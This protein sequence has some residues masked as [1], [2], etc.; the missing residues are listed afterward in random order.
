LSSFEFVV[1]YTGGGMAQGGR[2]PMTRY[3]AEELAAYD[4]V[5]NIEYRLKPGQKMK[6][7]FP[8]NRMFDL[9][10]SGTYSVQVRRYVPG[11]ARYDG[12][13]KPLPPEE[14]VKMPPEL[15]SIKQSIRIAPKNGIVRSLLNDDVE[16]NEDV[17]RGSE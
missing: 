16:K 2:V 12:V 8:L 14:N 11:K 5:K 1:Q 6:Y 10:A 17:S 3:G 4:A 7:E 15:E 13:G 9:T